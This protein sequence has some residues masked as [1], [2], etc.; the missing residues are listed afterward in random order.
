MAASV[1][2]GGKLSL[3]VRRQCQRARGLG[4]APSACAKSRPAEPRCARLPWWAAVSSLGGNPP[5]YL[6][7][8]Y[9]GE[10]CCPGT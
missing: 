9:T 4:F 5:K 3:T 1:A 7:A 6:W 10:A 2:R 8:V